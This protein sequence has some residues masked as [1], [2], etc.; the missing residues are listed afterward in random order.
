MSI[1]PRAD[2]ISPFEYHP[3]SC[4]DPSLRCTSDRSAARRRI[5]FPYRSADRRRISFPAPASLVLVSI[6]RRANWVSFPAPRL[7]CHRSECAYHP[8]VYPAVV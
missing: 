8:F 7:V 4:I 3:L 6:R 5:S 1:P 2:H